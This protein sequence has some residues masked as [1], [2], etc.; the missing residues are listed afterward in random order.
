MKDSINDLVLAKKVNL[1][2]SLLPIG[3]VATVVNSG[4]VSV[5]LWSIV[6]NIW[7][8][9]W[10]IAHLI[11]A[12]IR[13]VLVTI[14]KMDT[15]KFQ[16]VKRW[17]I[18]STVFLVI[19]GSL[20]GGAAFFGLL[21]NFVAYQMIVAVVLGGMSAGAAATYS[22]L[23]K[24]YYGFTLPTL[25]PQIVLFFIMGTPIHLAIAI[26]LMLFTALISF[27]AETNY[28]IISSNFSLVF[29][30]EDL[31]QY[32]RDSNEKATLEINRRKQAESELLKSRAD[33]E[34]KVNERTIALSEANEGLKTQIEKRIK[35]EDELK[36]SEKY[37]R[38][39]VETA[40]EG[41]WLI[42][43]NHRIYYT[44][45]RMA[46]MLGYRSDELKGKDV[47][48]FL[49][50][51]QKAFHGADRRIRGIRQK[52]LRKSDGTL[53]PVIESE[54]NLNDKAG[55]FHVKLGM[56][57]DITERQN[58]EKKIVR[59]N[60]RLQES[61]RE[62]SEF[63]H[64]VSHDLRSPLH[65]I[66]AYCELIQDEYA[67]VL[68]SD[69]KEYLSIIKKSANRMNELIGDLLT[70]SKVSRSELH[71]KNVNLSI[72][73]RDIINTL[74]RREPER[75]VRINIQQDI[76]ANCDPGLIKIVLENLLS[77]SWKFTGKT[78]NPVIGFGADLKGEKAV[79]HVSDNG[80]G[81][82]MKY[83][84]QLFQPFH[85][86]HR[87]S[88]FEGTGV[89]LA[90]VYRIIIKHGGKIW[91]QASKNRGATFYFTL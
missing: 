69:G 61:N 40:Q 36:E 55:Q 90:T 49:D 63:S 89:G 17:E 1:I 54:S 45:H 73:A 51:E 75:A 11:F 74:R 65:T 33:L 30:N 48:E 84:E 64:S 41:I 38:S 31:I 32:L 22:A 9:S 46:Q 4:I 68:N 59:L 67:N 5:L 78:E 72:I 10:L 56:V 27:S 83:K 12:V 15:Q 82:E 47:C 6:P 20:W 76:F 52:N 71:R 7:I 39:I 44:N 19:S 13:M 58:W 34:K 26:M 14:F 80:A 23:R 57:T 16:H 86:L 66:Q 62:L 77:N 37:Y 79:Y 28:R 24:T 2:F 29:K 50:E 87:E 53:I 18:L 8:L 81:F 60:N 35:V 25:V 3:I 88:E 85:R 42:G 43:E 70:L 91:A 21:H